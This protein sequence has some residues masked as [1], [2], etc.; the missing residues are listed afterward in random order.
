[1]STSTVIPIPS[2]PPSP[3]PDGSL[4][5]AELMALAEARHGDPFGVL[6]L[7]AAA[8]E[9]GGGHWLRTVQPGAQ[10]VTVLR[11]ATGHRLFELQD[12][13]HGVFE[14]RW[15]A[16]L[17]ADTDYRLQIVW[18]AG[19]QQIVDDP[20]RFP[21]VLGDMDVW[22]L[23]EGT[24]LRPFEMLGA[25]EDLLLGVAG[26]RFAVWA[27]NAQ[28]VSVVGDFNTWDGRRH[29]MRLRRECGVWELFI[30]ALGTGTVYKYEV[31]GADGHTR[32][33][34]DP[35]ALQA[36]RRPATA[37][38]VARQPS[39]Q[40]A[41]VARQKAN[42]LD[43][44]I[45]IYEVHLASWRRKPEEGQR[46]LNWDELGDQLIAH[47]KALHFTHLELLPIHEH[48]F[49][50]S[51][52]YQ[53][54]GLYAPTSRFGDPAAFKRFV[55]RCHEADL[56]L[57]IDWVPAHFPTDPH[58]LAE[59]D[60]T[61]LYEHADPREGFHQD[62]NTLIY[63]LGRN[64]VRNFLVGNALYWI[65]RYGVDGLRV[66]AV[67]SMLYRD[68]S[69]K[70]GEW[71]PN[72]HGGRE[73]LEAIAFLRRMNEVVGVECPQAVT[74]A[75]E[76]TA[77]P[78]VSRPPSM[79]GLGF[80][81]KWNM[82]W[83]H[84]TLQYMARDPIHRRYHHGELSFGLVYAFNENFVLPLSHDEVVHGKGSLLNK[85]PG[86]RWQKFANLRAYYGFMWGHPGKKLLFM[87]GEFA[88]EREW[89]HDTS[90]DWHLL[91]DPMHAGMQRL[92][93]DLNQLLAAAPALHQQDF[94]PAGFEWVDHDD[95]ARSVLSFVR[96]TADGTGL[97]LVVCNFTPTV[98]AG[99][100]LGVPRAGRWVERLNTDSQH[101]GGSNVGTPGAAA[102]SDAVASHGRSDSIVL[103]LP[104]LATVMLE[105][106]P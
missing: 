82:G 68:Y 52:G 58:G 27:P 40:P 34:A 105:W 21:P 45:S 63:N 66:D 70:A 36:E 22:L 85:M 25:R 60:G 5:A 2:S 61:H 91:A 42:A 95:A 17:A 64:E 9:H 103:T 49:D 11:A 33:K 59:F 7:R 69:R 92:V 10:R 78:A 97:M 76:S 39:R 72:E 84:D 99:F 1:V 83:M 41:S 20:Y 6:G 31:R 104:P 13:G 16:E 51:W 106:T 35:Y 81:Y 100:R 80:H 77:F 101:Y 32:L 79:G 14:A 3:R 44:P 71:V 28:R 102:S 47:T 4:S 23:A 96:R 18:G 50:G 19:A 98:H 15:P 38:I 93:A 43:A 62:W 87:G 46:W 94:T 56:G 55:Q 57:I 53:P 73:N 37:S 8:P 90:L 88:Q 54:V 26:T 48:P 30:P 29:P 75:E 86:D 74:L 65:E 89:N 24:H 67:A 12:R